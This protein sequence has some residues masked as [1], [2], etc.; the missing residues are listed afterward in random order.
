MPSENK[1][2]IQPPLKWAGGKRK[3][4]DI[5]NSAVNTLESPFSYYEPF[6]G[7]GSVFFDLYNKGYINK[8]YLNDIVPQ[9]V[10]FY[11]TI[12]TNGNLDE[13]FTIVNRIEKKFN[14]LLPD[15]EKRKKEYLKLRDEFNTLW[16]SKSHQSGKTKIILAAY[17]L[18]LNKLGFN[19]MFRV[20]TKGE[21]NI[22]VG[23]H[24]RKQLINFQNIKMVSMALKEAQF[25]NLDYKDTKPFKGVIPRN[26][27]VFLDPPYIP[28]SKTSNFT[29]YSIEGFNY[30]S[31]LLL[32]KKYT[33]L[34]QKKNINVILTN[35][36][37]QESIDIFITPNQKN[38]KLF[39]Y[40]VDITKTISA[41]PKSRGNTKELLLSTFEIEHIKLKNINL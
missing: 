6:F 39:A 20:N 41:D 17:F 22:P 2:L 23:S 32:G 37:N 26:N 40:E 36:L 29:D 4:I 35:N 11:D 27:F 7:G 15:H 14:N 38:R 28:N 5:I 18:A 8:A 30:D 21:F 31:H 3:M 12:R 16:L 19:G 1:N 13:F 9:V 10:N 25:T 24:S 33:K 34:I